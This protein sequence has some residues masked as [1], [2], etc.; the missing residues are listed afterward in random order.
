MATVVTGI[1]NVKQAF[2]SWDAQFDPVI[3]N[4]FNAALGDV[5]PILTA[6]TPLVYAGASAMDQ[7]FTAIGKATQAADF[8]SFISW[9]AGQ[10]GPA[11]SA[12]TTTFLKILG[13]LFQDVPELW[14]AH[15]PSGARTG[16]PVLRI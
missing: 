6:I 16:Q 14:T 9:L 8:K 15:L 12:L 1:M 2:L 3:L 11:V 5:Q 4:V 10:V 13:R 7:F